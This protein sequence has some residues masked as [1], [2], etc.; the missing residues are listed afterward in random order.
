MIQ[1]GVEQ[2][3]ICNQY[4]RERY[5]WR[6]ALDFL[7]EMTDCGVEHNVADQSVHARK[8]ISGGKL[9]IYC[10]KWWTVALDPTG[11]AAVPLVVPVEGRPVGETS[12]SLDG[13][14][15]WPNAISYSPQSRHVSDPNIT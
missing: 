8:I 4:V 11:V 15:I 9:S 7:L 13:R 14:G 6:K 1:R 12:Q 3:V 10:K 5:H 2:D